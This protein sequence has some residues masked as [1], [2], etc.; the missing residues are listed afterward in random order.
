LNFSKKYNA[1]ILLFGEYTVLHGSKALAIPFDKYFGQWAVDKNHKS[2]IEIDKLKSYLYLM[3]GKGEF[4]YLDFDELE[5]Q[6]TKG[7]AFDSNIPQGYGLG[8]SGSVSAAIFDGFRKKD[9][10]LE[11]VELRR[12]LAKIESCY[13]GS[14]SGTDPL[15]SYLNQPIL[16]HSKAEV[17]LIDYENNDILDRIFLVDT[18][19]PRS[20]APLVAAYQETRRSSA[21]FIVDMQV[22]AE[23]NDSIIESYLLGHIEEF[24][25]LIKQL[26][27]AQYNCMKMLIPQAQQELWKDGIDSGAYSMKL[28]GAGGGGFLMVYKHEGDALKNVDLIALK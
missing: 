10:S 9:S 7:L 3:Y 4:Q 18:K 12:E 6:I 20:T 23:L 21:E 27:K 25:Q 14:S 24:E 17:E 28:N 5:Y 11:L 8:S 16:I 15:V 19:K 2:R 22:I 1:K 13:H 26:S